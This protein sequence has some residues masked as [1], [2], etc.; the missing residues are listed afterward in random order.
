M[1]SPPHDNPPG[2]P[3]TTADRLDLRVLRSLRRIIR[4]V[5]LHSR[6][7]ASQHQITGPQLVCLLHVIEEGSVTV[8]GLA[9][10]IH[11]SPSTVIGI[12]DRLQA[13]DLVQRERSTQDRR[14]V[15]VSA[16][17]AGRALVAGAPSPLQDM[18]ADALSVLPA[19][20]QETIAGSL[21]RIVELM[22]A[23]HLDAAPILETGP[24]DP[25]PA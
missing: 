3:P 2:E 18:L 21:E 14:Q 9:K 7:L 25:S 13:K 22:E 23:R 12:L 20:E 19:K 11:L 10:G 8:S 4:A 6:Q 16:T 24:L 1:T 15:L 17:E 5:D